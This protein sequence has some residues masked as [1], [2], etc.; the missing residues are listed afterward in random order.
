MAWLPEIHLTF[1]ELLWLAKIEGFSFLAIFALTVG[2]AHSSMSR[3]AKLAKLLAPTR[4]VAAQVLTDHRF[5][6]H[7]LEE[8]LLKLP[9]EIRIQELVAVT[10]SLRGESRR[11]VS[12][13]AQDMGIIK[14]AERECEDPRWWKRLYAVR[15]LTTLGGGETVIPRLLDDPDPL[16]RAEAVSWVVEDPRPEL[17]QRLVGL[18]SHQTEVTKF[19]VSDALLRIGNDEVL[20]ALVTELEVE[21][22]HTSEVLEIACAFR[23]PAFLEPA[24][25]LSLSA[26]PSVRTLA[27]KLLG[28]LGG[29]SSTVRLLEMQDDE[30]DAV[31]SQVLQS[32]GALGYWQASQ[33]LRTKLEDP[34]FGVALSAA[35]ALKSMGA[36]GLVVLRRVAAGE[37]IASSFARYVL[38]HK[39]A[40]SLETT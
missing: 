23:S 19:I 2:K 27:A 39:N 13:L 29:D 21:K 32:L 14:S 4:E 33:L 17:V 8:A 34:S 1:H 24:L 28:V 35:K 16:V 11:R 38:D 37:G 36:P 10:T 22:P 3:E 25:R 12:R 15:L 26:R 31:R 9:M 18:L 7:A 30:F 5:D 6:L 20:R 40:L